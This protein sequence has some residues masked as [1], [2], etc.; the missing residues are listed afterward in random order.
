MTR[1]GGTASNSN[2]REG[3]RLIKQESDGCA[4]SSRYNGLKYSTEINSFKVNMLEPS[5]SKFDPLLSKPLYLFY[6]NVL[7]ISQETWKRLSHF[8]NGIEPELVDSQSFSAIIR[9]EGYIHNLPMRKRVHIHPMPSVTVQEALPHTKKWWPSWD[10]RKK[11]SCISLESKEAL[12]QCE[13]L[14]KMM[15]SSQVMLSKEKE[16]EI[17]H[18]CR[19][20]NLIWTG[21]HKLSPVTPEEV[22]CIL[23]YPQKHTDVWGVSLDD[24][25]RA[26]MRSFQINTV[27]YHLS[28]LKGLYPEGMNVL[29]IFSGIGGAEMALYRLGVHLKHVVSVEPVESNQEILR[30]W[31]RTSGQAG[32]LIEIKDIK[33]M[34]LKK[35]G[36][37][38]QEIGGFDI[39]IGSNPF[40]QLPKIANR[41]GSAGVN[42]SL[43]CEFVRVYLQVKSILIKR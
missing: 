31:W 38:N 15:R 3:D 17:L 7:D 18:H 4:E 32:E 12:V 25:L 26:L 22:E 29:S 33:E 24:R 35:I 6:G 2:Q 14:E 36:R 42:F 28:V 43:F 5:I 34:S 16:M 8:L 27:A 1:D 23:G 13:R 10:T 40:V 41:D 39:V 30:R 9:N 19:A 11:L 37:I 20:M 21:Q